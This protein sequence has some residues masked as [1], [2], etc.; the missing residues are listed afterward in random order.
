VNN[1]LLEEQVIP[2]GYLRF[3]FTTMRV[4]IHSSKIFCIGKIVLRIKCI[5]ST[6][7]TRKA[8]NLDDKVKAIN[9]CDGGKSCRAV[10]PAGI[11]C[12]SSNLLFTTCKIEFVYLVN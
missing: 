6:S 11:T 5:M 4:E 7:V 10:A 2:A 3:L 8:L 1:K 12:S 9:M